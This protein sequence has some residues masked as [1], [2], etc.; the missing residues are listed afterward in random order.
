MVELSMTQAQAPADRQ[1]GKIV[2]RWV[3]YIVLVLFALFYL[4]PLFVMLTTSLKSLEEIRTGDLIALPREVTFAAWRT[5]WSEA[6]TG[7]QCEGVRPFFWNSVLIA[8]PAVAISTLLGAMN[9][10]VVAQWSFRGANLFFSLMLFGCFIPFQVVLLPM[11]RVLGL[12][13]M[14]GTIPGL[15]F[16]HVIYGLGF[17]TLFFRNYYV[18]IP[19]ELTKAAKVDGAGF[20]RIFWSIF[21]PLSLPIIVVTVIWQFTQI[22]NDFLFGV[23]F[24]QA[25]T[26]PVTVAL[27][28]IVNST[29]GIKAY[30]V[31]MAAAII[32]GLPT[33]LVYVIAGKYFV[34]GLTAGSVKG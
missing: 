24:S 10:Y 20:F 30:N 11:A 17:T 4:L 29:T 7:I 26:Q 21:L 3:L 32:A 8:L 12:M 23:S 1:T 5:A 14:A 16:V 9:G 15:I 18:S 31:D 2:L 13:G 19:S 22:W 33:L 25:G 34:R 27:N 6:C 28:N